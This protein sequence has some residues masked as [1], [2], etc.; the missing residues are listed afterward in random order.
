LT[1][2]DALLAALVASDVMLA[3]LVFTL[4]GRPER[5]LGLLSRVAGREDAWHA[6][7]LSEA[8][9]A[10]LLSIAAQLRLPTLLALFL[11]SGAVG[12]ALAGLGRV[13]SVIPGG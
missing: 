11:W 10:H 3:A 5:L 13:A 12:V 9:E 6:G 1:L 7:T 4:H 2:A 8:E